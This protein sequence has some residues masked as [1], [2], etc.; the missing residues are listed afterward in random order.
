MA[1]MNISLPEPMRDYVEGRVTA[2]GYSTASE[3]IRDLVREDQR[4]QAREKLEGFLAEGIESGDATPWT[5]QDREDILR[6]AQNH[7]K[8]KRT[9][10]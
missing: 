8:A 9:S 1:T 3:Y 6:E 7:L 4:R 5:K 10:P 2:G